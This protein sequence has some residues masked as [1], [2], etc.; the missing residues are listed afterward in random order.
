M[1]DKYFD[2]PQKFDAEDEAFFQKYFG[3]R[4]PDGTPVNVG[5]VYD[6]PVFGEVIEHHIALQRLRTHLGH[7]GVTAC[8][9]AVF[10]Q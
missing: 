4:N 9:C 5:E 1:K 7:F 10:R 6:D 3:Q 2:K 8:Q